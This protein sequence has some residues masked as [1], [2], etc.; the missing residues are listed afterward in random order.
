MSTEN[1]PTYAPEIYYSERYLE[2][3]FFRINGRKDW[4]SEK[5]NIGR[6]DSVKKAT[7]ITRGYR[8]YYILSAYQH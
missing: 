4:I 2:A 3:W 8:L 5:E 7:V 6:A 1:F